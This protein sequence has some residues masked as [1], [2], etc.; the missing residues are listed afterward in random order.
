MGRWILREKRHYVG[1]VLLILT[2]A[3]IPAPATTIHG[4]ATMIPEPVAEPVAEPEPVAKAKPVVKAKRKLFWRR[5][6]A[7]YR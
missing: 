4:P 1:L 2:L 3:M 6:Y 7:R 5:R